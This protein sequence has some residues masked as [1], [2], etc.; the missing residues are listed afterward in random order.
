MGGRMMIAVTTRMHSA[1]WEAVAGSVV[2]FDI[3]VHKARQLGL[4]GIDWVVSGGGSNGG[5]VG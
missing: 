4:I 3:V 1:S 2:R 5:V